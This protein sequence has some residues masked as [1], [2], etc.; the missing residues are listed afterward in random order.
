MRPGDPPDSIAYIKD[1]DIWLAERIRT[2]SRTGKVLSEFGTYVSDGAPQGGP[3]SLFAGPFN[4]EIS[5]DGK[6]IAYEWQNSDYYHHSG[7]SGESVPP[8]YVLSSRWGVGITHSDRYTGP[9]DFGL[10]TGWIGP[11]WMSNDR[12]LRSNAPVSPNEDAVIND[13]GPGRGDDVM[14]RWFTRTR[15]SPRATPAST[16]TSCASTAC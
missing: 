12:L 1:G 14:K 15:R 16:V 2:L 10:I 7:C 11:Y 4:P 3:V 9:D 13:I 5:P 6:L 8:C